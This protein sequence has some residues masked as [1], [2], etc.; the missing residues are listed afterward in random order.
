MSPTTDQSELAVTDGTRTLRS[1]PLARAGRVRVP[2]APRPRLAWSAGEFANAAAKRTFDVVL[3]AALLA[4][5]AIPILVIAILVRLDSPGPS[6]YRCDRVGYRG[7]PLRMLKFRK[8]H[9]DATGLALT[10]DDD[11]RFTRIG[12]LLAKTKLDEL[13]QLWH[14][15]LGEMSFVGPRPEDR[16]FV[17]HFAEEYDTILRTRPG[18]IGLSQIAFVAESEILDDHEPVTHY[19]TR[20]MPQKVRM[21]RM[22]VARR[23]VWLDLRILFWASVAVLL[24][25]QVA[26]DRESTR[27]NL[28]RR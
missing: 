21:D 26:V 3:S 5:L 4:L 10:D 16:G 12:R 14:V 24:R 20:I 15:L 28:R 27:M 25:R 11:E 18:L 2:S 7:R 1:S 13:P 23:S 8:M 19:L 22:Y 6:F 17:S 9:D